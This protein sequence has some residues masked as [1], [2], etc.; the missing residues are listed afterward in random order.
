[1]ADRAGGGF[2]EGR[3]LARLRLELSWRRAAEAVRVRVLLTGASSF[4][5]F[6]F[7]K[8]L[9]E[10]NVEVVAPLRGKPEDYSGVR[11]ERVA[12]LK[13]WAQVV[14]ECPFGG[15]RFLELARSREYDALCHHAAEVRDYRSPDFDVIG[16]VAANT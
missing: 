13:H 4:T 2:A 9:T 11:A 12:V 7:A 14:P 3:S 15:D 10:A 16:A 1:M 5:G 8:T 6:W